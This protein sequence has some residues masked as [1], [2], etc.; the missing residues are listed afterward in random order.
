MSTHYTA[1]QKRA[2]AK[3]MRA[4]AISSARGFSARTRHF[5]P[6]STMSAIIPETKYFDTTFS[7][8][9]TWAGTSWADS[10]VPMDNYVNSSGVIAAYT[11]SA[12]IPSANGSGYGEVVGNRYKL[13]KFRCRGS[14]RPA[15]Q[16]NLTDPNA[17]VE[18]RLV[19][20]M[21]TQPNGAQAQGE[22]ILQDLGSGNNNLYSYKRV[23]SSSGRYRILKDIIHM[24]QPAVTS[25]DGTNTSSEAFEN[26]F[27]SFQ[28]VPKVPI[29]V[30]IKSGNATPT[31]AGLETCNIFM[32]LGS[33]QSNID[34][35]MNITG[36][37]RAYYC[38]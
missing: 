36:A 23:A 20:V 11:D 25:T 3:R 18:V 38:D 35:A 26:V 17:A 27:F 19:L 21:D 4:A 1:A 7:G 37:A 13:K 12:M 32:L 31:I 24:M 6:T 29:L 28:Y 16:Q 15:A 5:A 33:Q 34:V 8:V 10:E 14:L 22:D 30:N 9:Q 2:Y